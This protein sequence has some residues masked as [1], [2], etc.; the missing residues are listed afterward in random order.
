MELFTVTIMTE[1][2]H[3]ANQLYTKMIHE[4]E[5]LHSHHGEVQLHIDIHHGRTDIRCEA[6]L[7]GFQLLQ[8]GPIYE[9]AGNAIAEY[10]LEQ[11][12]ADL[13][14]KMIAD[15]YE[16]E[17]QDIHD[18]EKFCAQLL[19]QPEGSGFSG[20]EATMRRKTKI[21]GILHNYLK[22]HTELNVD[23]FV[24]FRLQSYT[25]EL[26][27]VAEYAIDEFLMEKQ[28]QEFISLLKYFVY[29]QEAKIPVAHLMHKG[30]NEFI[31]LNERLKPIETKDMDGFVIEL[32][33]KDVNFEDMIVSTLI[34]V[35]PQTVYI[36]TREPEMQ[37]IRTV[38]QIFED[39]AKLC[40]YCRICKT[41]LG[42]ANA[43]D[44]LYT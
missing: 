29:I 7:P 8:A 3:C 42:E 35:S 21:A 1:S 38:R 5:A 11:F 2:E 32:M 14:R 37:V 36:H 24:H 26:R 9:K 25:D 30:G 15:E 34:S 44:Q 31:L 40:T 18:I 6:V 27:E 39:R 4:F 13:M 43:Q 16:Y 19:N 23:G 33:D 17:E 10:I 20:S 41:A 12:E 28:Y 22:E